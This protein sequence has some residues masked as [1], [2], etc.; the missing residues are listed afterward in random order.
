M[1]GFIQGLGSKERN[2]N[3]FVVQFD[4]AMVFRAWAFQ[5]SGVLS[6][7]PEWSSQWKQ[8]ADRPCASV[9]SETDTA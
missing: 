3:I 4:S 8:D 6:T 7:T 9:A 5:S 1:Q 2:L